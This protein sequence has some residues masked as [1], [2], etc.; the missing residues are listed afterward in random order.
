MDQSNFAVL[1]SVFRKELLRTIKDRSAVDV[2]H[3]GAEI[4]S[5]AHYGS[6]PI[7]RIIMTSIFV[8]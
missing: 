6:L 4:N 1:Q 2:G 7:S 3:F 8:L 5:N